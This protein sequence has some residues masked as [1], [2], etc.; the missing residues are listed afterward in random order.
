MVDPV[1]R[2]RGSLEVQHSG[3]DRKGKPPHPVTARQRDKADP[4][5]IGLNKEPW[6]SAP[7]EGDSQRSDFLQMPLSD[8][9]HQGSE[10]RET[11][12]MSLRCGLHA[13]GH[14][15]WGHRDDLEK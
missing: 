3:S 6:W 10:A 9:T 14:G 1:S 11:S 12:Q 13:T 2:S 8:Q 15:E 4:A 5:K 7:R